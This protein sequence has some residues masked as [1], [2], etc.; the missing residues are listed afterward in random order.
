MNLPDTKDAIQTKNN[1]NNK[2][3]LKL[4]NLLKGYEGIKITN[5]N[6]LF[7][8]NFLP[9]PKLEYGYLYGVM[10]KGHTHK[11]PPPGLGR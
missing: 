9:S 8:H 6:L 4:D 10:K 11:T 5:S 3:A 7:L 2:I 1:N